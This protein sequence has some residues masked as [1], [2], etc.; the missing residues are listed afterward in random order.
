[1]AGVGLKTAQELM[2]HMTIQ[3]TARYAHLAPSHLQDA[4]ELLA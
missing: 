1:M 2:G 3:M 4:V